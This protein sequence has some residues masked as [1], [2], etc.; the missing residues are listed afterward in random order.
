[1]TSIHLKDLVNYKQVKHFSFKA[2][3]FFK[4]LNPDSKETILFLQYFR[5]FLS[6]NKNEHINRYLKELDVNYLL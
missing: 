6:K 4:G 2:I 1:M 5:E 3:N